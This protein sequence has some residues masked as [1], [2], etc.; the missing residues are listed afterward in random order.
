M[1][2]L[3][4]ILVVALCAAQTGGAPE[5]RL[6]HYRNLGK[7]YYENPT[8]Q[9][10]AVE[11]FRKALAVDPNSAR[12]RLNYGLALL[13]AGKTK[14]GVAELGRVQKQDSKLP[15]TWFNLGIVYRKEGEFD[16]A[17]PQFQE[18]TKLLPDEPVSHYNLGV[19]YKQTGRNEEAVKELETSAKLNPNL[20]A[21]H[22]QLYNLYRQ[23][24]RKEDAARELAGFQRLKKAQEGAVI[25]E[26]MEWSDYAEIYDPIDMKNPGITVERRPENELPIDLLGNGKVETLSWSADGIKL[27]GAKGLEDLKGV[28]SVAIGD[29]DNDGFPDLCVLTGRQPLLLHNVKGH[30]ERAKID[31]PSGRFE[32]AV[33]IDYDHDY[34][35]DLM[36]LGE[37]PVLMRNQGEAGFAD[38]TADF[39]F[40]A[41]HV[42]DATPFR[43]MA[44]SKA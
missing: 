36:L 7:A 27:A 28:V 40:V 3:G 37:K 20:A 11:E 6:W 41:G 18:M 2:R 31:L 15:H 38:H 23:A 9:I 10:Q 17:I 34:D 33:W 39:P 4:F 29:Y 5:E 19:L 30:F 21:P 14:D 13:R 44:D 12:D 1:K 32:K 26:D 42:I 43:L 25:A 8:T 24:G 16:K 35:Q 22:F